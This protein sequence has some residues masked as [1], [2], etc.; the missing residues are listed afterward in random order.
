MF[1]KILYNPNIFNFIFLLKKRFKSFGFYLFLIVISALA[2]FVVFWTSKQIREAYSAYGP[3][4][5][6]LDFSI[7]HASCFQNQAVNNNGSFVFAVITPCILIFFYVQTFCSNIITSELV[8]EKQSRSMEIIITSISP[9]SHFFSKLLINLFVIFVMISWVIFNFSLF[10][11]I[12]LNKMNAGFNPWFIWGISVNAL[13]INSF[14]DLYVWIGA[15]GD[16]TTFLIVILL[17]SIT[18]MLII[19]VILISIVSTVSNYQDAQILAFPLFIIPTLGIILSIFF[20]HNA[21]LINALGKIPIFSSS[22]TAYIYAYLPIV[23]E[24]ITHTLTSS[25]IAIF[26]NFGLLSFLIPLGALIYKL[27][28]LNYSEGNA[29]KQF[30][31]I[32]KSLR[33]NFRFKVRD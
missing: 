33:Y 10:D 23:N 27:G 22:M 18:G 31:M 29:F 9:L 13:N 21:S 3:N 17:T 20:A 19:F 7:T 5:C 24:H 14:H 28:I 4:I 25:L 15:K 16:S 32:M 2:F 12:L 30:A 1:N 26:I 6:G 11:Y 8:E